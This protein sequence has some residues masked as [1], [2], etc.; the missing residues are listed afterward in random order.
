MNS[1]KSGDTESV[2]KKYRGNHG[3]HVLFRPVGLEILTRVVA[4]LTKE[5]ELEKAVKLAAQL[6]NDLIAGAVMQQMDVDN[7]NKTDHFSVAGSNRG[8]SR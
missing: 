6:P 4:R 8:R 2:V 3:G 7:L 1:S 5:M